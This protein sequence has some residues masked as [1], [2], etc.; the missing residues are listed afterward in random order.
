MGDGGLMAASQA[1]KSS[2][3]AHGESHVGTGQDYGGQRVACTKGKSV[4]L[5]RGELLLVLLRF[6]WF[7]SESVWV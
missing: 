4:V 5:R 7:F 6:L 2:E 3:S 1:G